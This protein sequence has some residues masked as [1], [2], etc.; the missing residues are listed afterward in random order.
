MTITKERAAE[1]LAN[2]PD[3]L[4][5]YCPELGVCVQCLAAY[6]NGIHHYQWV[7][8]EM[9]NEEGDLAACVEWVL[10]S[11]PVAG[12]EEYMISDTSGLPG[13]LQ[14][15]WPD[16]RKC[17]ELGL[18][19]QS[20]WLKHEQAYLTLCN[21]LGEVV[22]EERFEE[23]F[24]GE[25]SAE[26]Y[27]QEYYEQNETIPEALSYHIDWEGLANDWKLNGDLIEVDGL[28]FNGHA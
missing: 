3:G 5:S 17:E 10:A 21:Y 13:F 2:K 12:A 4:V 19:F 8:L 20:V 25:Q 27:V 23:M 24:L 18:T 14:G 28:L 6:N 11:S 1:L 16:L 7:D 15:Q 22:T 9:I 26:E